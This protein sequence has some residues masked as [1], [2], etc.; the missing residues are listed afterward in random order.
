[1]GDLRNQRFRND[2]DA[3][4]DRVDSNLILRIVNFMNHQRIPADTYCDVKLVDSEDDNREQNRT[5]E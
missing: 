1:M 4:R 2:G 5:S 3:G